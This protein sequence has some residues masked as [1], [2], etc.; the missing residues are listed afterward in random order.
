MEK[1]QVVS[2]KTQTYRD[3]VG[4]HHS[5][6]I[7]IFETRDSEDQVWFTDFVTVIYPKGVLLTPPNLNDKTFVPPH[8]E[9]VKETD[10]YYRQEIVNLIQYAK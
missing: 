6:V 8:W 4:E 7:K 9:L 3:A 2:Q 1:Q 5:V 10:D